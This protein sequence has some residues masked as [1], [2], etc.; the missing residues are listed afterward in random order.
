MDSQHRKA[1]NQTRPLLTRLAEY[2]NQYG[3][4]AL[5][6]K[7]IYRFISPLID[8][9]DNL[10]FEWRGGKLPKIQARCPLDVAIGSQSDMTKIV[11]FYGCREDSPQVSKIRKRLA[12][13]DKPYLAWSNTELVHI[14]WVSRRKKVEMKEIWGN[15]IFKENQAYVYHCNTKS[16]FRGN[17]IFPVVLQQ[18]I[19]DAHSSNLQQVFVSCRASNLASSRG[20]QKAG[21][22][23][24]RRLRALRIFGKKVGP[25]SIQI[26]KE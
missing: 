14:S 18:I 2:R 19:E 23:L 8:Y 20:I 4:L 3:T 5:I 25:K 1:K 21:F 26:E 15:L 22:S 9:S 12:A 11:D 7:T 24:V 10:I 13:G 16:S 17:H 6:K